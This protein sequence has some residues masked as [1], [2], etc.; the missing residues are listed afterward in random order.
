MAEVIEYLSRAVKDGASDLFIVAGG[1]VSEKLGKRLVPIS[2]EKVF[3]RETNMLISQLFAHGNRD[4]GHFEASG[5]DDF[6]FSVPGL[7][8]FRVNVYRQ[9]GSMAAVVRVVAFDIPNHLDLNIPAGVLDLADVKSGMILV[10]GTA[11]SGK[12]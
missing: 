10:T 12:F 7:A 3:P 9:R 4:M 6:S 5:D 2:E 1:Q 8:R 11:G